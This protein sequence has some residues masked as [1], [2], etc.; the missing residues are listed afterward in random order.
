MNKKLAKLEK[1]LA[2]KFSDKD[3][4]TNAFVH[5]SYL[6]ESKNFAYSNE[7]L[8]FLGD[9]VLELVTTKFLYTTYP[10]YQE[11]MLTSLRASLVKTTTLAKLAKEV[12]FDKL[13]LM[14]KGE[15]E[16]GGRSNNSLLANTTEA[17]IGALYLSQ[18][19][20]AC[21]QFLN[22]YLFP[23]ITSIIKKSSYKDSKSILQEVAQAKLKLTPQY[24][25]V[26]DSGPDHNKIFIMQVVIGDKKYAK[27]KGKNKQSSQE[28]A[29]R[30]TLEMISN[31]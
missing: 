20:T 30:L 3:L 29:A 31:T 19:S 17:F 26:S 1:I 14:S 15:E 25:L 16:T 9:A 18:G 5:R 8:E 4:I 11:G 28:E 23:Q 7:R 22:K 12:G 13:L 2:I 10:Q 21:Q 24:E 6:N 27:G